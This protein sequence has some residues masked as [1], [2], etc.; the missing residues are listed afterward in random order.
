MEAGLSRLASDNFPLLPFMGEG[1]G[2]RATRP[3]DQGMIS[4]EI[5][6]SAFGLLA[7]V[8]TPVA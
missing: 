4:D 3:S 5:A 1:E 6:T 8:P 2:V 7:P